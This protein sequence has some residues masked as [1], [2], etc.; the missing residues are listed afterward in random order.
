MA[1]L[2]TN[3]FRQFIVDERLLLLAFA[4]LSLVIALVKFTRQADSF[5]RIMLLCGGVALLLGYSLFIPL[6]GALE[7]TFGTATVLLLNLGWLCLGL[8][9]FC[10]TRRL[11]S[12]THN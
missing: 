10:Y 7:G 9:L 5:S 6:V 8:G 2:V 12:H 3:F 11:S 1:D 4:N